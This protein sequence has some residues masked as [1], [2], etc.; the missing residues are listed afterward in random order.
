MN[1]APANDVL[2]TINVGERP[3]H[4]STPIETE[5]M[6]SQFGAW[7]A[8]DG[9]NGFAFPSTSASAEEKAAPV[10]KAPPKLDDLFDDWEMERDVDRLLA[11]PTT[12]GKRESG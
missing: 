3:L 5:Q 12:F 7:S 1:I 8:F 4:S 2:E 10:E 11:S 6:C 9:E